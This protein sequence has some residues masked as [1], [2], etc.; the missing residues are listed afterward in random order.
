[1]GAY[2]GYSISDAGDVN[3]DG[4]DDVAVGAPMCDGSV[5]DSG[6]AHLH[7]GLRNDTRT[8]LLWLTL[9]LNE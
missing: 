4:A 6:R 9:L 5:L 1:M 8:A 7:L 3:G 2:Y